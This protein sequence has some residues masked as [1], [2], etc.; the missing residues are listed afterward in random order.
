MRDNY[1]NELVRSPRVNSREINDEDEERDT[2][3]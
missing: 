2:E 3:D 1:F